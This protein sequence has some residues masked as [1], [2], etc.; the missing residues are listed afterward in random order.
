VCCMEDVLELYEEPYDPKRPT[1]C[2]DELPYQLVSEKRLPL[3]AKPGRPQRFDYE[4]TNGK[5]FATCSC[6]SNLKPADDTSTS[7]SGAQP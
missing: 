3:P 6:S 1:V 5:G 7:E 4:S 2:F